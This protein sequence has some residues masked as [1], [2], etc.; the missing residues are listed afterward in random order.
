MW[1]SVKTPQ[2]LASPE[3]GLSKE[4]LMHRNHPKLCTH[5]PQSWSKLPTHPF[6]LWSMGWGW[7][8]L[9]ETGSG[10]GG[11]AEKDGRKEAAE[12]ASKQA[13]RRWEIQKPRQR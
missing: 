3:R 5:S 12:G 13:S 6:Q 11:E 2:A 8:A 10:L 1:A 4:P 9:A 7:T